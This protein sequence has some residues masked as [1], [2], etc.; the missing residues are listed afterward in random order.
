MSFKRSLAALACVV[1]LSSGPAMA[2]EA[3]DLH[4]EDAYARS[5]MATA[6]TGAVFLKIMNSG[7][8]ADRLIAASTPFAQRTM[9]HTHVEEDGVMRM[10]HVMDGF[11]VPAQSS[12]ALKRGG[13]HVMLMGLTTPLVQGATIPLTLTFET[14]GEIEIEVDVDLERAPD[15]G[16]HSGHA[17][18]HTH[19]DG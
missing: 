17:H 2:C 15:H 4:V 12:L 14:A 7:D 13:H 8:A 5:A 6:K 19:D 18:H 11:E 9:L 10:V 1:M 16:E 3:H